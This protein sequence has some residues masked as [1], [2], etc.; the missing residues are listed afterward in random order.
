[1]TRLLTD[2]LLAG[3]LTIVIWSVLC[4]SGPRRIG[5]RH[6]NVDDLVRAERRVGR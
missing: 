1:M 6:K 4:M 5:S 2:L 3:L